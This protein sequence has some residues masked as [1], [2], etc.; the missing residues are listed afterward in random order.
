M[1]YDLGN[2]TKWSEGKAIF[3]AKRSKYGVGV[4]TMAAPGENPNLSLT[5]NMKS[6]FMTD[7]GFTNLQLESMHEN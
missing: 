2:H 3:Q 7:R 4:T 1:T 5:D 6:V